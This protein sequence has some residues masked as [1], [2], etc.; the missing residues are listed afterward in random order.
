MA[1]RHLANRADPG[2]R[3]NRLRAA[4]PRW[5]V[6]EQ[7]ADE[8]NRRPRAAA[9]I[10]DDALSRPLADGGRDRLHARAAPA[11]GRRRTTGEPSR[12][13]LYRRAARADPARF[14]V[15]AAVA[16][17][18]RPRAACPAGPAGRTC[19]TTGRPP[20]GLA[21]RDRRSWQR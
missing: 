6:S 15:A 4:A 10:V 3:R 14:T 12:R 1:A 13:P 5:K 7:R 20:R 17:P 2:D 11:R 16:R 18:T 8:A 9:P 21:R 19:G